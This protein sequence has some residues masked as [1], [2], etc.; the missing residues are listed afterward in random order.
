MESIY[1]NLMQNPEN[2]IRINEW[3]EETELRTKAEIHRARL[4]KFGRSKINNEIL[5]LGP[6]GGIYKLTRDGN[7]KYI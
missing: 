3:E 5:F 4:N 2:N 7:K 6:K 1:D